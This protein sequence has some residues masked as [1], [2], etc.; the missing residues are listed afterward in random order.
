MAIILY[1]LPHV[2]IKATVSNYINIPNYI[3]ILKF[4]VDQPPAYPN[5]KPPDYHDVCPH[6][7]VP[8]DDTDNIP[9]VHVTTTTTDN[10]TNHT[11]LITTTVTYIVTST[12]V[13]NSNNTVH[14]PES[15]VITQPSTTS[16]LNH[17]HANEVSRFKNLK[18]FKIYKKLTSFAGVMLLKHS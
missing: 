4:H 18:Y 13:D 8:H 17:N 6:K 12:V 14:A 1:L 11:P 7:T 16:Q 2:H 5:D 9:V 10:T 3:F 15:V